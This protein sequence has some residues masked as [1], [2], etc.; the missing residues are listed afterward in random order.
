MDIRPATVEDVNGV[1][2]M[3]ERLTAFL[4]ERDAAKYEPVP[5]VG[6]MYQSWLKARAQDPRAVFLVAERS[7]GHLVGFLIGTAEREIPI[8]RLREYGF[9]HDVWV[10]PDYRNE[11]LAR[12]MVTL[13][14]ERFRQIG[15]RQVRLDVL[16]TNTPAQNLFA[17]CGFR[18]SVTE[19]L[20]EFNTNAPEISE[21]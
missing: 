2:P 1:V 20:L 19:M 7:P 21:L 16:V 15:V 10:E 5:Q 3:V 8:Y 13:A 17:S 11:G 12:Q 9:V 18:A 14:G 4:A 6:E